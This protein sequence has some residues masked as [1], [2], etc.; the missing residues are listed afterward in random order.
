MGGGLMGRW[1][2]RALLRLYPKGWR[3]RYGKE[4]AALCQ[5]LFEGGEA[6]RLRLVLG[7]AIPPL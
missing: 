2:F 3:E 7:W 6:S 5:D 1:L 4:L